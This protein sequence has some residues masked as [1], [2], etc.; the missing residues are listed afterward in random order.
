MS[1]I[2]AQDTSFSLLDIYADKNH[3]GIESDDGIQSI[4]FSLEE[5][6]LLQQSYLDIYP[7][8]QSSLCD[9]SKIQTAYQARQRQLPLVR[10]AINFVEQ[11]HTH[12]QLSDT[13]VNASTI[14]DILLKNNHI[15][16]TCHFLEY[17]Y[18]K[19]LS[20]TRRY[21]KELPSVT[22]AIALKIL[23]RE[24]NPFDNPQDVT[25][26]GEGVDGAV[27]KVNIGNFYCAVK[28]F[29][30]TEN[31]DREYDNLMILNHPNIV[32]VMHADGETI[33]ME[34]IDGVTL[35]NSYDIYSVLKGCTEITDAII[36]M[37]DLG[38]AHRDIKEA[39][40]ILTK[41]KICKLIDLGNAQPIFGNAISIDVK[42]FG[43]MIERMCTHQFNISSQDPAHE[44]LNELIE[45][46][47]SC[48][49]ASISNMQDIKQELTH[50]LKKYS[51]IA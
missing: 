7:L 17:P 2:C 49:N 51:S 27:F 23:S 21:S 50:L 46:G 11:Y 40:I 25:R 18:A 38:F 29:H 30:Q 5:A 41:D 47:T 48:Q 8:F 42:Q 15:E 35:E 22:Q 37:H 34:Y 4:H 10:K 20:N 31:I 33:Y 6:R 19:Y 14:Q 1:V 45:L 39:N 3:P 36:Y 13:N 26:L 12:G 43:E 44:L 32:N 16:N 9:H 28:V 24:D